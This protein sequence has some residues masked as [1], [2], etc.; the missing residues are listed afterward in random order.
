MGMEIAAGRNFSAD[1]AT[2]SSESV[3]INQTAARKLGWEKPLGK[4]FIFRPPPGSEG[5][6]IIMTV[7]GVVKDFHMASLRQKIEPQIIFYDLSS[8]RNISIRIASDDIM[9]T[10]ALLRK[11]WKEIDPQ[12]PFDYF[13]LDEVFDSQ[14]RAEERAGNLTLYFSLLAIFIGCLG[15]FG[16]AAFMAEKRTKEIGIRK[17]LGAS[18]P[19]IVMLLSREFLKWVLLANIIAWPIAWY[20]MNNWLQN[21]AYRIN[22]GLWTFVLAGLLALV[23][24]LLTVSFQTI[25][26]TIANPVEALRYE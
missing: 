15:L 24:A 13:F 17:V 9:H 5:E 8:V 16:L 25:K 22:I 2:D 26:A 11:K 20:G 18:A 21:F 7:I 1:L 23:I 10:V 4:T 12:R 14:Y 6:T 3:I 19:G